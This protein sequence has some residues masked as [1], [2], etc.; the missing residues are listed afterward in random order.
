M[1]IIQSIILGLI[2][3]ISE[4]LPISSTAHLIVAQK[5]MGLGEVNEF[6]TVIVQLGAIAGLIW[7]ERIRLWEMI[8]EAKTT[9]SKKDFTLSALR[10]TL[11]S[12]L[13]FA[14]IPI[15]IV[16]FL[17]KD[18]VSMLQ[19]NLPLIA[20]MSIAI[21][22]VLYGAE[23]Y[24]RKN[25][26]RPNLEPQTS[27]LFIMGVFQVFALIPGVSRSGITAVGGA[28]QRM[29][30]SQALEYSFLLSIPA[31]L[32][33]GGYETLKVLRH[34]IDS[35]II[36]PTLIATIVS[37]VCAIIAIEW[38]RKIVRERGFLPFVIYRV[39]FALFILLAI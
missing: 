36:L 15:L 38:L 26:H 13:L 10:F 32:A 1:T 22:L 8:E 12:K 31:L 28:I 7:T 30:L 9:I 20:F 29:T 21:G 39:I 3:G 17:I 33:A 18:Y 11:A 34:P 27:S 19:N 14:T 16:G 24:A 6:F 25:V 23:F 35:A 4:F 5:L 37:F 2:E